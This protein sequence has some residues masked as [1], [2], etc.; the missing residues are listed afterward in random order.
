MA[1]DFNNNI[2]TTIKT[3]E[4]KS[5]GLKQLRELALDHHRRRFPNTPEAARYVKSYSDR[6]ANGLTRA[7][8]DF[9]RFSGWQAERINCTGRMIDNTKVVSDVLGDMRHIGS[10]KWLPTSGEKGTADI[11][12]TIR[13][14]SVKIEVKMRDWQSEAQKAYQAKVEQAGGLYWLVRSFEEFMG[15]YRQIVL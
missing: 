11:S 15:K 1:P 5:E 12:A 9:L 14:R 8:I 3:P 13:G 10:V 4:R 2:T 7:I 6:T